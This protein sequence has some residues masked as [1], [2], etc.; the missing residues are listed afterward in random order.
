[1]PH[2][3]THQTAG[4]GAQGPGPQYPPDL[5]SA[6]E[7][8]G[9]SQYAY[10]F[11]GDKSQIAERLGLTAEQAE[12]F[13]QYLPDFAH[14]QF[15]QYLEE[16]PEWKKQQLG[17][18]QEQYGIGQQ[19]AISGYKTGMEGARERQR[20]GT[21]SAQSRYGLG[22]EAAES[23]YGLGTERV[24][25][26]FEGSLANLRTQALRDLSQARQVGHS[27]AGLGEAGRQEELS[28]DVLGTAYGG[29]QEERGIGLRGLEEQRGTTLKGL[30]EQ[31]GMTLDQLASA[32][33]LT[34]QQLLESKQESLGRLGLSHTAGVRQVGEQADVKLGQAYGE[35]SAYI[36]KVLGLGAQFAGYDPTGGGNGGT[37]VGGG[38]KPGGLSTAGATANPFLT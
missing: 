25:Q 8:M 7:S 18:L 19:A 17:L 16:I 9:M 34:S 14:G 5:L 36:N 21:E 33:G 4:S 24:G 12:Q 1:M 28:R 15:T 22:T 27:F 20:L 2:I 23:A 13:G 29:M 35:L 31:R 3:P 32:Y 38:G 30:E 11:G 6:L 26:R 10:M 37:T